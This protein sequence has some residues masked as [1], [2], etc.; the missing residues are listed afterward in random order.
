MLDYKILEKYKAKS[1]TENKT[2]VC[3]HAHK[4]SLCLSYNTS[5]L[6]PSPPFIINLRPLDH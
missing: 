3:T 5:D 4:A 2:H 1:L 6:H